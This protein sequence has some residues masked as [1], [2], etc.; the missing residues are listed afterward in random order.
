[1]GVLAKFFWGGSAV[2]NM[3]LFLDPDRV[4]KSGIVG[5][6]WWQRRS[7]LALLLLLRFVF[8]LCG[9]RMSAEGQQWERIAPLLLAAEAM[10]EWGEDAR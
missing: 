5:L 9:M 4:G 2:W 7:A 8:C 6:C 3:D 1:V 10:Y